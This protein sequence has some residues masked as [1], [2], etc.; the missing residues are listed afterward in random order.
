MCQPGCEVRRLPYLYAT[1]ATHTHTLNCCVGYVRD[2]AAQ[3]FITHTVSEYDLIAFIFA[4][5]SHCISL[6]LCSSRIIIILLVSRSRAG[7]MTKIAGTTVKR[8]P[9]RRIDLVLWVRM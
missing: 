6:A 7:R 9:F 2:S 1:E 4:R 8:Y 3:D 5:F